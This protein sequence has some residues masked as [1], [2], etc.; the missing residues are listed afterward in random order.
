MNLTP[1]FE[2]IPPIYRALTSAALLYC[3]FYPL[4]WGWLGFFAIIPLVSLIYS[5]DVKPDGKKYLLGTYRSAYIAGLLFCLAAF[6]WLPF[7]S[8]PMLA[9]WVVLSFVVAIQFPLFIFLSRLF[10]NAR[11]HLPG[12][13]QWFADGSEAAMVWMA[14]EYLRAQIWI[15]FP[16]YYLAHTQH[17]FTT[18]IQI[19]DSLGVYGVSFMVAYTNT[20]L[21]AIV[22]LLTVPGAAGKTKVDKWGRY[23]GIILL[24]AVIWGWTLWEGYAGLKETDAKTTNS[25]F[26]VG[27]LQGN[28][29]QE[30]RNDQRKWEN[31]DGKYYDLAQTA[32]K[33]KPDLLIMP[34]TSLSHGWV[35]IDPNA[36]PGTIVEKYLVASDVSKF[37]IS[38]FTNETGTSLLVGLN[39]FFITP[40][41]MRHTNSAILF[42]KNGQP[43]AD[44]AKIV[45][46]P[47]GEY[48]PLVDYLPFMKYLSPYPVEYTVR[49][50]TELK[51][52]TFAN[53]TFATLICYEDSLPHLTRDFMKQKAPAF[54]VNISNDGW[55]KGTQEHEQH[56]VTALFRCIETRRAMVRSVNMGVSCIIDSA[57]R[58]TQLI[59]GA[60]TYYEGKNREG[61]LVGTVPLDSRESFYMKWGDWFPMLAWFTILLQGLSNHLQQRMLRKLQQAR[62]ASV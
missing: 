17:G 14:I 44:Y 20:A 42:D 45:C 1:W 21:Y 8:L 52:F 41:N 12:W 35:E 62:A 33:Q 19:A 37:K 6:C 60:K 39:H 4:N 22:R 13:L 57:G 23:I 7:A 31:I 10:V 49:P 15:G 36:P 32:M 50:G 46:L 29:P 43:L 18:F 38:K 11:A 55:F 47:F 61:V 16:W 26:K 48:I 30:L 28:Q 2:R 24:S 27:V 53:T 54:F 40:G 9:T 59:D 34:E 56:L 51:T 58:V 3:S 25:S 5:P